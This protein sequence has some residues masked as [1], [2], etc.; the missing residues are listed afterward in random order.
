VTDLSRLEREVRELR[1][2]EDIKRLKYRYFR[3]MT[4]S[5]YDTLE[6]TLTEDVV[7]SYSDGEYVFEDRK[8]L[9]T[10]LID[11]H[12]PNSQVIAYWMAGM[13]EITLTSET[14]ATAIWAMYH[15]FYSR[16]SEFVDEMFVYYDDEYRKEGDDWKISLTGYRRVINQTLNRRDMPY[17]MKAPPWAVE[18]SGAS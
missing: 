14:T 13:P 16:S 10:F 5:D 12:D 2:F 9:L 18:G 3:A 7:T 4:F 15:Y 17:K 11:S 6:G 8:K 1:A